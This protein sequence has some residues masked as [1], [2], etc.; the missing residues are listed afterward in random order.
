MIIGSVFFA[1]SGAWATFAG[2]CVDSPGFIRQARKMA[3]QNSAKQIAFTV[4]S[5]EEFEAR[6]AGQPADAPAKNHPQSGPASGKGKPEEKSSAAGFNIWRSIG[7]MIFVLGA[8]LA[9]HGFLRKRMGS[10]AN[11]AGQRRIKILEKLPIDARRSF[12][13]VEVNGKEI[14]VGVGPERI[15]FLNDVG[16]GTEKNKI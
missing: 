10:S 6:D 4:A 15:E 2:P 12:F 13:L 5:A 8:L 9:I 11:A 3:F 14:L 1:A 16:S 7:A